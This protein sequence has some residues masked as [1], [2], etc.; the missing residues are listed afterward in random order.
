LLRFIQG[1]SFL[2]ADLIIFISKYAKDVINQ[3][4]P[5]RSGHSEVIPHGVSENFRRRAESDAFG[6]LHGM[7]YVLYVS[8]LTVYKAQLEV[9]LAWTKLRARRQT[10]E[11]LV[12]VG[13]EYAPYGRRVRRLIQSLKLQDEVILLGEVPHSELPAYYQNAKINLFASSCEN[14]PNILLEAMSAGKPLLCSNYKPMPELAGDAA[15]YFNPYDP[16]E[17]AALLMRYLD[18]DALR[19]RTGAAAIKHSQRYQWSESAHLTWAALAEL[20][21]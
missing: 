19:Q 6:P 16:E 7:E 4:I 21:G 18:D 9:I 2:Y 8:I 10:P 20:I 14:C 5:Q 15:A 1:R 3:S 12:I 11:K 17:L 13:P